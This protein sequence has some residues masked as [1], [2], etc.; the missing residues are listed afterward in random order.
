[1]W[2][3]QLQLRGKE[4]EEVGTQ[5][6]P[7]PNYRFPRRHHKPVLSC[8]QLEKQARLHTHAAA[9]AARCWNLRTYLDAGPGSRMLACLPPQPCH[10][11]MACKLRSELLQ[12]F[13]TN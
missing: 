9:V 13:G 10:K 8:R 7:L 4:E 5:V 3:N 1:M 6:Y 12:L 11:N 2:W